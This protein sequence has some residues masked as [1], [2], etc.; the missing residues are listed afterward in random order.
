[1]PDNHF[2]DQNKGEPHLGH[3]KRDLSF[4]T[5]ALRARLQHLNDD[6]YKSFG[7]EAG[8]IAIL[9][10]IGLNPGISQKE[11]ADAIVIKKSAMTKVVNHMQDQGYIQRRKVGGD[12]R[13]NSLHLTPEGQELY[14]SMVARMAERQHRML[15]P[16]SEGEQTLLFEI[17]WRLVDHYEGLLNDQ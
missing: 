10:I 1:M 4:V 13:V 15:Q 6:F 3:L 16:L 8:G 17:L 2:D 5:R 12:K 11:L 9:N 7:L 14:E